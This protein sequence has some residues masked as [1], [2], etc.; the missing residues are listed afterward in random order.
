M[1]GVTSLTKSLFTQIRARTGDC[2]LIGLNQRTDAMEE[3]LRFQYFP[4]TITDNKQVSW[5]AKPIAGGSL[6]IYQWTNSGE[7]TISFTATLP[8]DVHLNNPGEG[9]VSTDEF[10]AA[11]KN[12]TRLQAQ[13]ESS[14]NV[15]VRSA[16]V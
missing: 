5:Q 14:K 6:P 4:E 10:E 15:D 12:A 13:G 1:A 3:S 8:T 9:L 16:L 11:T 2:V 7:R